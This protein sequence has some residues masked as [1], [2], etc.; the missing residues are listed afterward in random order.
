[1]ESAVGAIPMS[2]KCGETWGTPYLF[3]FWGMR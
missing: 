2:R 1:L 3:T